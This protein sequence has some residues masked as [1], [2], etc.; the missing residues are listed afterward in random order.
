MNNALHT[1]PCIG[2]EQENALHAALCT[3]ECEQ[4]NAMHAAPCTL[5]A[6]YAVIPAK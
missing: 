2:Y 6:R 1:A 5:I 4:K 3:I